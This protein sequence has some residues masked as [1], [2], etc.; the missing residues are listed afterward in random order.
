MLDTLITNKTRI[1]LL[2]RFFLNS[3]SSSY[4]RNLES[5]FDESTNAIRLELN[6]FEKAGL[7]VAG[8]ESNRKV[9]R[10]NTQ[11][12]LYPEIN[13]IVRKYFGFDQIIE[14]VVQRLGGVSR[15]Y[16]TGDLARGLESK[17]INLALVCGKVDRDYL[18]RLTAKAEKIIGRS[19][20]CILLTEVN[21][22]EY[23]R[24]FPEALLIWKNV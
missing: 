14:K 24:E 2:L 19:I 18:S 9:Y 3:N 7:L 16:I 11:H 4:L 6:R 15:A 5:E 22:A 12:P 21:E 1:K 17:A 13:N 8:K 10:A 20:Q 23:I